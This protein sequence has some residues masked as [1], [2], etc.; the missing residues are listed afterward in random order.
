MSTLSRT[1]SVARLLTVVRGLTMPIHV[2]LVVSSYNISDFREFKSALPALSN[3]YCVA[4]ATCL[5]SLVAY[6]LSCTLT[7][8]QDVFDLLPPTFLM[9]LVSEQHLLLETSDLPDHEFGTIFQMTSNLPCH[10]PRSDPDSK[11][12]YLLQLVN[13]WPPIVNS[14]RL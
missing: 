13:Y 8:K 12:T 10:S 7:L 1:S 6:Q 14:P 4:L 3:C 5:P 9:N 2:Y 11:F